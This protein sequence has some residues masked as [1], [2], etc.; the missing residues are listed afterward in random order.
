[1]LEWLGGS[2]DSWV[3]GYIITYAGFI[4][5]TCVAVKESILRK[6]LHKSGT[7]IT[8]KGTYTFVAHKELN[9]N[10]SS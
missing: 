7:L 3:I 5:V 1:M 9:K 8:R 2:Y 4:F 6:K 10:G